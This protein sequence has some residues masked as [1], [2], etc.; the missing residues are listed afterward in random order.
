MTSESVQITEG[1]LD[2][3]RPASLS[4]YMSQKDWAS[5]CVRV[6]KATQPARDHKTCVE[7]FHFYGLFVPVFFILLM[8]FCMPPEYEELSFGRRVILLF[9]ITVVG[10]IILGCI[11]GHMRETRRPIV[12]ES[13][14]QVM[15]DATRLYKGTLSFHLMTD[16]SAAQEAM[17]DRSSGRYGRHFITTNYVLRISILDTERALGY[18]RH[19]DVD[20]ATRLK[21]LEE[22]RGMISKQEYESK[23][24]QI[25]SSF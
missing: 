8:V 9:L 1:I 4:P 15:V 2:P 20:V 23:R 18:V 19:E 12:E 6:E 21:Q 3:I 16:G 17:D 25:L 10:F 24:Q 11:A 14:Q 13:L 5:L 22:I 7:T